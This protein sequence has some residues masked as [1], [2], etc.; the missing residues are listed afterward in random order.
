[1][2]VTFPLQIRRGVTRF[3]RHRAAP[4]VVAAAA[5]VTASVGILAAA[6]QDPN[7]DASARLVAGKIASGEIRPAQDMAQFATFTQHETQPPQVAPE[8]APWDPTHIAQEFTRPK[9]VRP[10]AGVLTSNFGARWGAMH[11]GLDFGD[12]LGAPIATVTDGVVIEAGPASGFGLWVRVQQ[13]D[14]TVGVYGHVNDILV[15]VGQPVRAGDVIATVGNRGYSTGPHLHYEV[16][17]PGGEPI[18][19]RPWLAERGIDV[20]FA[21]ED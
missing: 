8:P 3:R 4:R 19:P 6:Q 1:M 15:E 18:D 10:V 16:H 20:G 2:P 21:P 13:D 7:A 9:T 11:A 14:G 17:L 5:V 12:P